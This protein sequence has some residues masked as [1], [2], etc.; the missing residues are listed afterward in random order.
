L[1]GNLA[2]VIGGGT[3]IQVKQSSALQDGYLSSTDWTTFNNKQNAITLSVTGNS[4]SATLIANTLNIPT[5]TLS[6]LG[7]QT[8]K[9]K[10]NGIIFANLCKWYSIC[11]NDCRWN[12]C[13]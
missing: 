10:F 13:P 12:I 8:I 4:G 2:A 7:G 11:K 6:G 1:T 9:R 3:T 5:Y